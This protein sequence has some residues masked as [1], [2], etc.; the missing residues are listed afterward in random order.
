[1]LSLDEASIRTKARCLA[2]TYMPNKPDKYAIHM[3]AHVCWKTTYLRIFLI[4][5]QE[6]K[7]TH[8]RIVTLWNFLPS[9]HHLT[10]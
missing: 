8:H 7:A 3:Y 1:M 6:I 5:E 10:A 9:G 2:A 4:M